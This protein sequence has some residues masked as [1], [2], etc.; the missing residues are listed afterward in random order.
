MT[1]SVELQYTTTVSVP[2]GTPIREEGYTAPE[3]AGLHRCGLGSRRSS[4]LCQVFSQVA[5]QPEPVPWFRGAMWR[6]RSHW[7][8]THH[9]RASPEEILSALKNSQP[10][11]KSRTIRFI[12]RFQHPEFKAPWVL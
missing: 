12:A 6:A 5:N 10:G 3:F 2:R 7:T 11:N 9:T 4:H 8:D 1:L